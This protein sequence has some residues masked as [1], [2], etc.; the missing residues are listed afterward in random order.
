METFVSTLAASSSAYSHGQA[1][2][3]TPVAEET[4]VATSANHA[5]SS[6]GAQRA[7]PELRAQQ[8][9]VVG[10]HVIV[11]EY[12]RSP[13][14]FLQCLLQ[15][16]GL[17]E[18][19]QALEDAGE[20]FLI[21]D[22]AKLF[23]R[24]EHARL[25]IAYFHDNGVVLD[26]GTRLFYAGLKPRHVLYSEEFEHAVE[27]AIDNRRAIGKEGGKN[28][29]KIKVK[30]KGSFDVDVP[31]THDEAP[32]FARGEAQGGPAPAHAD[33]LDDFTP[34]PKAAA[35]SAGHPSPAHA[36][37][38]DDFTPHPTA[39]GSAAGNL[40]PVGT[41]GPNR[42]VIE[43][44]DA[45]RP[46]HMEET[47]I[48]E[49]VNLVTPPASPAPTELDSD[50][51]PQGEQQDGHDG[52][53]QDC[54]W[55]VVARTFIHLPVPSSLWSGTS[56]SRQTRSTGNLPRHGGN[57]R[58]R[59]EPNESQSLTTSE[60]QTQ[61]QSQTAANS[62]PAAVAA[63]QQTESQSQSPGLPGEAL[64]IFTHMSLD[65]HQQP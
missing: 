20:T 31:R 1:D 63:Q 18:C 24:P 46:P 44:D 6:L 61:S 9:D 47:A 41:D 15:G 16:L 34:H 37:L 48:P 57:K 42:V 50:E 36:D 30:R 39:A 51:E 52:E 55:Q 59:R 38:L 29:D 23:V 21:G 43:I 64:S 5:S 26:N 11:V 32:G 17:R 33:L 2:A 3:D 12:G 14:N 49:V 8:S 54:E 45:D 40:V 60:S 27:D 4:E 7:H 22:G 56:G 65:E 28:K 58:T 62:A 53:D 35:S 25:V 10:L 13:D 19:R